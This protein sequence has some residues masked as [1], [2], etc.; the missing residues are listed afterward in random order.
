MK[1]LLHKSLRPLAIFTFIIFILSIPLYFLL[2]DWIWMKELDENNTL[3]AQRIE[4]EF[5]EQHISAEKLN[6]SI[7]FWNEIQ[8]VSRIESVS[9][10]SG[11]DSVYTI[12]RPNP[13]LQHTSVDRFRGLITYIS[14]ND[15][16]FSLTIETNVEES[17]ETV[18][19]IAAVTF[20]LFFIL[21]AGFWGMHKRLS[22]KLWQPFKDTLQLLQSFQLNNHTKPEFAETDIA[23]FQE[24]HLAL[25]KLLQHSISTY[26]SQKEFTENASHELQTP[27]AIIKNKLD[28]L[29]QDK[30][31]T[32]QQ[33]DM[34]EEINLTLSR[35]SRINKSLL[36]LAQIENHQFH[37]IRSLNVSAMIKNAISDLEDFLVNKNITVRLDSG[38]Q[39]NVKA[40]PDLIE[41]LINNLLLNAIRYSTKGSLIRVQAAFNQLVIS[42]P[43]NTALDKAGLF[44]RFKKLSSESSGSGLGL[45]IVKEICNSHSWQIEYKFANNQH[46]FILKF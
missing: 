13:Y 30:H 18:A 38:E 5:N 33:Y 9:N 15:Q 24:L 19:Y 27:I 45:A 28:L 4:N 37:S 25:D 32:D 1:S 12:R 41:I 22:Q 29:L 43:G 10:P 8:P 31:L 11:K 34:I 39:L 6:E 17:E 21:M 26:K 40:N 14:I 46:H 16:P 36:L 20:L 3:I 23:E 44:D 7:Q 42:N 35:I 2:V